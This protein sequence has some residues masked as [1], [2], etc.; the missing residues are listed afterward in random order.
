VFV[1]H[2][3]Y[4]GEPLPLGPHHL[5]VTHQ[6]YRAWSK[7]ILLEPGARP[8]L[9]VPLEPTAEYRLQIQEQERRRHQWALGLGA[10]SLLLAGGAVATFVWNSGR[11]ESWREQSDANDQALAMASANM[12][13]VQNNSRLRARVADLRAADDLALGLAV[14]AGA[15]ALTAAVLWMVGS[16]HAPTTPVGELAW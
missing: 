1:D 2:N 11:Y 10:G 12:A 8:P 6:N 9:T 13:A 15:F 16:S 7:D 4:R 5:Q 14:S 3:P